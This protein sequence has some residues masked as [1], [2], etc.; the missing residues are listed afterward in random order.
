MTDMLIPA[1]NNRGPAPEIGA[2]LLEVVTQPLYSC[3]SFNGGVVLP[4]EVRC[5]NYS[6]GDTVPGAGDGTES[7]TYYH[8]NMEVS[9]T[10]AQPKVFEVTGVRQVVSNID[11]A[12]T[13]ADA[14]QTTQQDPNLLE[15]VQRFYHGTHLS[16]HVG[17][18]DYLSGPSWLFPGNV[19]LSGISEIA[20]HDTAALEC[21][22]PMAVQGQGKYMNLAPYTIFIP[23]Q[24]SFHCKLRAPQATTPTIIDDYLVYVVLDGRIGREAQ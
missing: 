13:T 22:Q 15:D 18:K 2:P 21:Y 5:F 16:L 10:L 6:L 20:S 24:Q 23:S 19:G 7:A 14:D 4:A 17:T 1:S 8:T 12:G 3:M 9:G 11:A